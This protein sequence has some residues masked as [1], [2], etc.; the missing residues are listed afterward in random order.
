MTNPEKAMAYQHNKTALASADLDQRVRILTLADRLNLMLTAKSSLANWECKL[1]CNWANF[2]YL[3]ILSW[4]DTKGTA[5]ALTTT[6]GDSLVLLPVQNGSIADC[7]SAGIKFVR[8]QLELDFADLT[9]ATVHPAPNVILQGEYYIQP[10]Q[11]LRDLTNERNQDYRLTSW[12]GAADLRT[13]STTD[14]QREILDIT[15]QDDPFDLLEPS[16]NLSSCRT[17]NTAVYGELKSLVVHLASD[18]IHETMFMVLVPGYS[19][20]P[21]NV[22]DHIWQCYIDAS[23]T[24]VRLSAQV[25]YS[26]FL[27]AVRSFYNLE[28]YPI[29]LAEIFQDHINP[30]LQKGFHAH[31]LLNNLV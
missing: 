30:S 22:F 20:E 4:H 26:I 8:I 10:P 24:M 2:R 9:T 27:N 1:S 17:D 28:E 11:H 6:A 18:R 7:C 19:I 31:S 23:R 25:Y 15:H 5:I 16:F 29:N 14:V 12:L 21:H 3:T 13:M